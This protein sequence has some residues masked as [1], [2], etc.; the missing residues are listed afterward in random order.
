MKANLSPVEIRST[1]RDGQWTKPT[2]G[3]APGYVQ[4]NLVMLF[5]AHTFNF[6]LFCVQNTK[7]FPILDVLEHEKVEPVIAPGANLRTDL[8]NCLDIKSF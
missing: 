4:A 8:P 1:I 5:R 7:L 2:N 3:L 6:L